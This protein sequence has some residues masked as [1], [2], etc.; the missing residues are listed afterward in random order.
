REAEPIGATHSHLAGTSLEVN[1][2]LPDVD[3]VFLAL[4]HGTAA[5]LVPDIAAAGTTV[6]DLGPDFRLRNPA[7][8]PRWYGFEHPVPELLDDAVYGLPEFHR[9]GLAAVRTGPRA[10]GG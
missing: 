1:A 9:A 6:I 4:P 5:E 7:D 2:A 3:A 10:L 8:Y